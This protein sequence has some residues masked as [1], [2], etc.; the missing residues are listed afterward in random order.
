MSQQIRECLKNLNDQEW[1]DAIQNL[2]HNQTINR[3]RVDMFFLMCRA[4]D[5]KLFSLV[6]W[7]RTLINF[8]ELQID[9]Q[10]RLLQ[11]S[12]SKILILDHIHQKMHNNLPDELLLPNEQ[13]FDMMGMALLGVNTKA[14]K[15]NNMLSS[16]KKF[17]KVYNTM[18]LLKFDFL[19]YVCLKIILLLDSAEVLLWNRQQIEESS[20]QVHASLKN[21]CHNCHSSVPGKYKALVKLLPDLR[22]MA[23]TGE[24]FLNFKLMQGLA[25]QPNTLLAEMLT[26]K[27]R[28]IEC[29]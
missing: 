27:R 2:L 25:P 9:D 14:K 3:V 7:A 11:N 10:M 17:S 5:Q 6:D 1:L 29:G 4:I 13:K 18:I 12:W 22:S 16:L 21:H 15:T 19:D 8:I 24:D 26:V 28:S 23:R 20:E